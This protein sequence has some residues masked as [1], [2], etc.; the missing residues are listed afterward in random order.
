MTGDNRMNIL[1]PMLGMITLSG[2]M[3]AA[4]FFSRAPSIIKH[5]GNLQHAKHSD[6]LRPNLPD[7][8]RYI[9][10]NHNHLFEQPTLFYAIVIYIYLVKNADDLH[11]QLA[12]GYVILR[13]LHSAIHLTT[14]NVSWR[15]VIFIMSGF[16]LLA[17]ITR[18]LIAVL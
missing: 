8:M 6:N 11:I 13:V 5:W 10:D 4:L 7:R 18:E 12:W 1:L 2:L 9:T 15:A 16:C 3:I 17:M 14:N